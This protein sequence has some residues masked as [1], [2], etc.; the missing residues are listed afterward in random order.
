MSKRFKKR[1]VL[2][3]GFDPMIHGDTYKDISGESE[4]IEW[5]VE[6]RIKLY[7]R[8]KRSQQKYRLILERVTNGG[9]GK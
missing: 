3:E 2:G 4:P 1:F 6:H 7:S 8:G 9:K 5:W